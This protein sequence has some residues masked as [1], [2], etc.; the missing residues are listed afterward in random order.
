MGDAALPPPSPSISRRPITSNKDPMALRPLLSNQMEWTGAHKKSSSRKPSRA[1]GIAT[2]AELC[3]RDIWSLGLALEELAAA[4]HPARFLPWACGLR[5]RS[6]LGQH[7]PPQSASGCVA[8]QSER[9]PASSR[10]GAAPCC[11]RIAPAQQLLTV[12]R[13]EARSVE[14]H[15]G[16]IAGVGAPRPD[17]TLRHL[18]TVLL[19]VEADEK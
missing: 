10:C 13:D 14:A 16:S 6:M 5:P 15:W 18:R 3:A 9:L 1:D 7:L 4:D 19:D 12:L 11:Q 2:Y 17:R 8:G